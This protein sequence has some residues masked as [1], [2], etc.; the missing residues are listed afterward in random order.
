MCYSA[1]VWSNFRRYQRAYGAHVDFQAFAELLRRRQQGEKLLLPKGLTDAFKFHAPDG[2]EEEE[3]R[4][5]VHAY[6]ATLVLRL[7]E[8]L[9]AQRQR[10]AKAEARL[11]IKPSNAMSE[12]QRIAANNI[13]D[14]ARKLADIDRSEPLARDDRIFTGYYCPVL[15]LD[16]DGDEVVRPMRFHC[17]PAGKPAFFDSKYPGLYNARRDSLDGFWRAQFGQTHA[18]VVI[19]AF[20]EHVKRHNLE[21]R[22]LAA[23][24]F[25]RDVVLR[26]EA[27]HGGPLPLACLWSHWTGSGPD[28]DSFALITDEPP[29]EVAAAGHDRCPIPLKAS[30]VRTWLAAPALETAAYDALLEDKDHPLFIHQVAA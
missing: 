25:E 18:V 28:L 20:F 17:R 11:A 4:D 21:Q 19:E 10:L 8:K 13:A 1:Q 26:F 16:E 14:L 12:E 22:A 23:G 6:D 9:E 30:N 27:A 5:L 15:T 3:C 7:H 24:E 2:G 29:T